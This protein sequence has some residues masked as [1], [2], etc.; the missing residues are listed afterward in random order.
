MK[1]KNLIKTVICLL[2]LTLTF[3]CSSDDDSMNPPTDN[4]SFT[5]NATTDFFINFDGT[6]NLIVSGTF[7]EDSDF[8]TVTDRGF[9]YGTSSNPDSWC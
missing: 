8:G 1:T 5:T 4:S 7:Q 9:V 3:G 2:T 6:V